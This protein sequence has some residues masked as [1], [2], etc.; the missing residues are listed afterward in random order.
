MGQGPGWGIGGWR[1]RGESLPRRCGPGKGGSGDTGPDGEPGRDL[2]RMRANQKT[3]ILA[4]W[5]RND[6]FGKIKEF[7]Y[8]I[9]FF[10]I[11][12]TKKKVGEP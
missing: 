11:E 10:S 6:N 2:G 12:L 9:I 7:E 8:I 4:S 5:A 1:P 3:I